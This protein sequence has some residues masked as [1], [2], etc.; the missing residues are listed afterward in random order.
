LKR[1][2]IIA[3][4]QA[5]KEA[6]EKHIE[7]S[8]KV[9]KIKKTMF[10]MMGFSQE[11]ITQ[12]PLTLKI[13]LSNKHYQALIKPEHFILPIIDALKENGAIKN[14]DYTIKVE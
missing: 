13:E 12:N 11:T 2:T 5:G 3:K 9:G 6:I 7:E 14:K 10:K 8:F 4:T 1:V